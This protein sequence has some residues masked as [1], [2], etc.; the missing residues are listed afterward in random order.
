MNEFETIISH[1]ELPA[2][3]EKI[4]ELFSW[5]SHSFPELVPVVKWNQPMFTAHG[6]FIIAFSFSKNHFAV[7]PETV[8]I[9]HF[10]SD[11]EQAGY[12]HTENIIRIKWGQD[13]DYSL[14]K[15]LIDFNIVD[16]ADHTK[17]WR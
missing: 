11:I 13:I 10:S 4:R 6:T 8:T 2:H 15:K 16:K 1:I 17:F 5:I 9:K 7:S 3:R 14:M 12:D